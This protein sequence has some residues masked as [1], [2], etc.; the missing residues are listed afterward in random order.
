M[1]NV[2][3]EDLLKCGLIPEFIGRVPVVV[4]LESL[5][6]DALVD[7]LV[8]PKNALVKQYGKLLEMDGVKLH[9]D[10]EALHLIAKEALERKTGA[11][12][13]RSIIERIMRDVMFEIPSK[14]GAVS[15]EITK[16]IIEKKKNS[17]NHLC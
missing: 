7:I 14:M 12:G 15:C 5:T 2:L 11:R 16:E 8:K 4:T 13:L 17:C 3:P 1:K 10:E 6:E 9:F